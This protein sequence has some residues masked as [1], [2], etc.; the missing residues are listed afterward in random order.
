MHTVKAS[1]QKVLAFLLPEQN[2]SLYSLQPTS[3]FNFITEF[4]AQNQ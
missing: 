4:V 2:S 1:I 3:S